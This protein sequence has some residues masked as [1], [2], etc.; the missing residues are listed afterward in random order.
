MSDKINNTAKDDE[1]NELPEFMTKGGPGDHNFKTSLLGGKVDTTEWFANDYMFDPNTRDFIPNLL[2]EGTLS[3]KAKSQELFFCDIPFT[4]VYMEINGKYQACCFATQSSKHS[5]LNTSLEEWM[6]SDELNKVRSEMLDPNS[7]FEQ[8]KR[9]CQRCI[10]DE[11]RYGRSRRTACMKIHSNDVDYWKKVEQMIKMMEVSGEYHMM[12]GGRILEVQLKVYGSECNLDCYM[13]VHANSTIRQ[14]VA[15]EGGVWSEAIFE[16]LDDEAKEKLRWVS[17]DKNEIYNDED[18]VI[19][20]DGTMRIP[21][22]SLSYDREGEHFLDHIKKNDEITNTVSMVDQTI[23]LAPYIRSIKIIGGEPLIM[24]KHYELL[25]KLIAIDEAKNIVIKYQTNLT[26]T[27]AGKH[28]IFNYIPKFKL[29]CMVAS[30][31]GIGKT[32]EYMR[33]RTDWD[34]VVK[35]CEY[36]REYD[37]ANV[38]FNGLVSFLSVMRFYEVIDFCLE[39][40][41]VDQIN[42]ALLE[43]PIHLRVNNLPEKIKQDLIPKYTLWPDIVAALEMEA[44]REVNIQDTFDYLLK[45]DE[46]YNGTKW[47][48]QLFD[49]FPELEEYYIPKEDRKP[50]IKPKAKRKRKKKSVI[51]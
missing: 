18:V 51:K 20:K 41:I 22:A 13:C 11:E 46:Y 21:L 23:A 48:M 15:I 19:D 17:K 12:D 8:T 28:N 25:D 5:V 2:G 29:V 6:H 27:K 45:A 38:D 10:A 49:V 50:F 26:E 32:I 35:N 30:V 31:D 14:K 39:N 24:K 44:D 7:K 47:E 4:Q 43:G 16:K 37:N 34:K 1:W 36:C 42:W 9:T 40:P 33:R 3:E